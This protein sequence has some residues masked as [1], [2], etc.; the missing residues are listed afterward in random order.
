MKKFLSLIFVA[1]F[2]FSA[3]YGVAQETKFKAMYLYNFTK[4]IGWPPT[5]K[6]G[7]FV[8]AVLGNSPIYNTLCQMTAGKQAGNQKIVVKKYNS[9]EEIKSAHMVF[10]SNS[11]ASTANMEALMSILE[12]KNT[13]V[14]TEKNEYIKKGATINFTIEGEQMRFELSKANALKHGLQISSSLEKLAIE[15]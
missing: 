7:D 9:V 5:A 2:F 1:A 12:N 15:A 13:L 3:K 10:V 14:V 8:I 11:K 4:Q 6:T